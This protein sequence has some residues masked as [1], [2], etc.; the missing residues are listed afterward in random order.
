MML[1]PE[2]GHLVQCKCGRQVLVGIILNG[3]SH[4]VKV[5]VT[6]WECLSREAQQRATQ[7]Y[8]LDPGK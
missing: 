6:C 8:G 4:N 7:L 1:Y 3:S 5:I 2:E